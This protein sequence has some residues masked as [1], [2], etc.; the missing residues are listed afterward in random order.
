MS[1]PRAA[2]RSPRPPRTTSSLRWPAMPVT[3]TASPTSRR[4]WWSRCAPRS[5]PPEIYRSDCTACA[6]RGPDPSPGSGP[7]CVERPEAPGGGRRSVGRWFGD[8]GQAG[9]CGDGEGAVGGHG[10]GPAGGLVLAAVVGGAQAGQVARGGGPVRPG[11]HVVQLAICG[12]AAA[13]A[14]KPA[15]PVPGP[16]EAVQRG[17]GVVPDARAGGAQAGA[18]GQVVPAGQRAPPA[19]RAPAVPGPA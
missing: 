8:G 9:G 10:V 3:T 14:G 11:V 2:A 5:A 15:A 7:R 18:T 4:A 19:R 17:T 1:S 16:G 12:H 13:A 6:R